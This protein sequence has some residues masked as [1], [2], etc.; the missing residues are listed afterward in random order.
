MLHTPPSAWTIP[1]LET[2]RLRLRAHT[3]AD[4]PAY[5]ALWADPDVMRYI[6]GKPN[7]AEESWG[8]L[9]R[10]AGHWT[11][12]G[13]GSW[14]IEE[15]ST[16]D[17]LGEVGLFNYK[18][19]ITPPLPDIPEIG[20]ILT[21]AKHGQGYATEAVLALIEWGR[22]HF[23]STELACIIDPGNAPSLRVASKCGFINR[24]ALTYRGSSILLLTHSLSGQ[25]NT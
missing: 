5:C 19:D 10:N 13:F 8:R 12:L 2:E 6:G 3:L 4:F 14:L 1:V 22:A 7:T 16:G 18:R 11:L 23:T 21:P 25:L 17:F 15:K 20:W 24:A 9:L